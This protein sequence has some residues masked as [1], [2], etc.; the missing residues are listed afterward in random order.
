ME[1]HRC[2]N[3]ENEV[4]SE[5]NFC[6]YCGQKTNLQTLQ[7]KHVAHDAMHYIT[8]ADKSIF[9]LMKAL[10]TRPGI[11]A[12]EYIAG[13]RQKY[14][15]PLNFFLIVAG[16]VVFMTTL[17]YVPNDTRSSQMIYSANNIQDPVKKQ[18]LLNMADRMKTVNKITG[19]Y[20]N[21]INMFATPFLTFLFW[22][23]YR[24]KF[25]YTESLVA[26]MYIIGLIMLLYA[27]LIVPLQHYFPGAGYTLIGIFFLFEITY[28]G[29]AFS[30]LTNSKGF[31][32]LVKAY[33]VS[34]MLTIVWIMLTYSLIGHYIRK[35]F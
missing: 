22:L 12:G 11:V 20:S 25:N 6:P 29:F 7:L 14:F 15:K 24:R 21:I 9:T 31:L 1:A 5:H 18:N 16:I 27:L 10:I 34:L 13:K 26:N 19:K 28:R 3:C 35:G 33:G 30:Q 23:F 2:L 17:F 8:H 4:L 32:Q